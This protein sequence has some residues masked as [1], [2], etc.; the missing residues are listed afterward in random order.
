MAE[1]EKPA[2]PSQA[3]WRSS[4]GRNGRPK[5]HLYSFRYGIWS[6]CDLLP[7]SHSVDMNGTERPCTMCM[8]RGRI[9]MERGEVVIDDLWRR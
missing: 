1:E 9:K 5:M 6:F 3:F 2:K 8:H 7:L 4:K